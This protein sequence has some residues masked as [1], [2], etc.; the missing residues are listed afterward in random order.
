MGWNAARPRLVTARALQLAARASIGA[1]VA[2][3]NPV[4]KYCSEKL[5]LLVPSPNQLALLIF[6]SCMDMH[7]FVLAYKYIYLK[8]SPLPPAPL[9]VAGFMVAGLAAWQYSDR[10]DWFLDVSFHVVFLVFADA[11][12][13]PL[14]CALL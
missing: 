11:S 13:Q 12:L 9:A 10:L 6:V 2:F 5:T 14:S 4:R 8:G 7:W 1:A 3:K